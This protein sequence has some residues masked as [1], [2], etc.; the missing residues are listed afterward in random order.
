VL[1]LAAS[2]VEAH[3]AVVTSFDGTP[4]AVHF[5]S[6]QTLV[7]GKRAPTVLVGAG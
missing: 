7:R 4:I 5:Y 3:G 1:T 2:A 6:S